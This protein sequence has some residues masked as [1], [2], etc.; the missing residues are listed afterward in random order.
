MSVILVDIDHTISNAFWRDSM[1][2]VSPWDEYHAAAKDDKAFRNMVKLINNLYMAGY[3]IIAIT[4]RN[5][6]FRKLT[7][8][9]LI[10]Q[11]VDIEEILMRPDDNFLKNAEMKLNLIKMR[12]KG[13]YKN[14]HFLIDD[15]E[16]TILAFNKI[17]IATLQIRNVQESLH[18]GLF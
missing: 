18:G 7:T 16:D 2:G 4:G 1:I 3:E 10:E 13:N 8:D 5:E 14:I 6:R 11:E 15:N 17:G 9:W 12:F